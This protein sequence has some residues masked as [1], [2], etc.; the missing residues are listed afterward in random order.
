MLSIGKK[1][2][3]SESIYLVITKT[4]KNMNRSGNGV[5]QDKYIFIPM[6]IKLTIKHN[7]ALITL[8]TTNETKNTTQCKVMTETAKQS[9]KNIQHWSGITGYNI[10]DLRRTLEEMSSTVGMSCT[11]PCNIQWSISK[12]G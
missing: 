4:S 11:S 6:V 3:V 2:I 5:G 8:T 10:S 12:H 1:R 7:Y 9:R